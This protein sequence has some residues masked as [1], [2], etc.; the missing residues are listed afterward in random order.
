MDIIDQVFWWVGAIICG[1]GVVV[2]VYYCSYFF[3]ELCKLVWMRRTFHYLRQYI[4]LYIRFRRFVESRPIR[5][6]DICPHCNGTG[7]TEA[8]AKEVR[9]MIN[10]EIGV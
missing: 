6:A 10:K 4:H 1:C 7:V 8:C 3:L 9:D 2:F 5:T